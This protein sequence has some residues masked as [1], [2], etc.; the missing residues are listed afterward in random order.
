MVQNSSSLI[1]S[2][3][4]ALTLL[5][6]LRERGRLGVSEAAADLGVA[7]STAHRLLNTLVARGFATQGPARQYYVGPQTGVASGGLDTTVL[8]H[9]VRPHLERLHEHINETVH[10]AIRTGTDIRLLDGIESTRPLRV[11]LRVGS[12]MPAYATSSGK[13]ML[14][15]MPWADVQ[16]LHPD[17]LPHW[18]TAKA[19]NLTDLR[20]ELDA[21][22][23]RGYGTNEAE[24]EEGVFVVGAGILD[25]N[26]RPIA[27]IT[28]A[29]P[30][31]RWKAPTST[32]VIAGL[33]DTTAACQQ[34]LRSSMTH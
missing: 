29:V 14:A 21:V 12:R 2:V 6:A 30:R 8:L 33:L 17:G 3:D 9:H 16:A 27:A 5:V 20:Q 28:I 25:A 11:G 34:T 15:N 1:T 22:R 23:Q 31:D 26:A 7:P 32:D 10:L 18:P 13:A 4:R 19:Q 24:T